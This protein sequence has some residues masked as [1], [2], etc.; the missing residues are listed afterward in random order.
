M[1]KKVRDGL[2]G[3]MALG[4]VCGLYF[5]SKQTT[6]EQAAAQLFDMNVPTRYVFVGDAAA[7]RLA[8]VDIESGTLAGDL[9]LQAVPRQ[10]TINKNHGLLAY[11]DGEARQV[12][13]R[14]LATHAEQVFALPHEVAG[15]AFDSDSAHLF[16]YGKEA[17][18]LLDA[19]SGSLQTIEG[20]AEIRS[21][22]FEPFA[23]EIVL[24]DGGAHAVKRVQLPG[25]EVITAKLPET[26][27][28]F[29][30]SA[31]S[32]GGEYLL[33]GV[34][35]AAQSRHLGVVWRS[36]DEGWEVY[37]MSA[38]LLQPFTDNNAEAFFFMDESGQGLRVDARNPGDVRSFA[39]VDK[40][41]RF[42]LGWLDKHLLVAGESEVRL[43]DST[44]LEVLAQT[45]FPGA[46][47]DIFITA[48]SK[49]ALLT[50]K[51]SRDLLVYD[52]RDGGEIRGIALGNIEKPA[53]VM[54]G[55]GYTLCH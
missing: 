11:A 46:A 35:D 18:S 7:S 43:H 33:F 16:L 4:V 39:S 15:M 2:L 47:Q 27:Q 26:W 30:A 37:P 54:M 50:G 53:A 21:L 14:D 25:Q 1:N 51:R 40:P 10:M 52:V 13:V 48:D 24:L 44:T 34:Y 19:Q 12:A 49:S 9:P 36:A 8:S 32:P 6:P 23:R 5:W 3:G 29:T 31:L 22:H 17:L 45:P 42:A 41:S 55:A 28:D 38:P 20:F